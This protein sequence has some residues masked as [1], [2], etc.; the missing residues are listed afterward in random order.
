MILLYKKIEKLI[1]K[2][3]FLYCYFMN[4]Q[5]TQETY[6]KAQLLD[7]FTPVDEMTGEELYLMSVL[8]KD[9]IEKFKYYAELSCQKNN[10]DGINNLLLLL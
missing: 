2:T 1:S 8:N 9:N 4:I 3:L 5:F 7:T 6:N 10:S